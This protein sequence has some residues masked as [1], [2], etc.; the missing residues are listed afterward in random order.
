MKHNKQTKM[1]QQ[2]FDYNQEAAQAFFYMRNLRS[3]NNSIQAYIAQPFNTSDK[4][5]VS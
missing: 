5:S 1:Q 2:N 3:K 4:R